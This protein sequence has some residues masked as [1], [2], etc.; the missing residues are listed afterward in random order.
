LF[1]PVCASPRSLASQS[2]NHARFTFLDPRARDF[3]IDWERA[4]NE[5]VAQLRR[6]AGH[7]PYEQASPA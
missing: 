6:E 5:C 7:D 4:A 3:W 1:A 2:A